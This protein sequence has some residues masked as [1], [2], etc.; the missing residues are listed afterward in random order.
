M[1]MTHIGLERRGEI[2]W[3]NLREGDGHRLEEGSLS[4]LTSTLA[5]LADDPTVRVVVLSGEQGV[6]CSG[7]N[8]D[9][10]RP[11]LDEPAGPRRLSALMQQVAETPLPLIAAI[12]G[13]ALGGGLELA[14]A[15][16]VRLAAEGTRFGFPE[17]TAGMPP[18]GGGASRLA[19]LT[20]PGLALR[21][22]LTGETI[23]ADE[24][25]TRGLV[26]GVYPADKLSREAERLAGVIAARGPIAV[27][28][29]KEAVSRGLEMPLDQ[30]LRFETDLTI[31]LQSTA[32]RAEGVRAFAEKRPPRF[33]GL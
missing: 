30:A 2:A 4:R 1:V 21:L 31:I 13:E 18:L 24:A 10:V 5:A 27:R 7:W 20:G 22:L 19:R 28:Y 6:F 15:C 17:S 33:H 14:L 11:L 32:D 9:A 23:D 8:W 26:S 16:D 25:L 3:L 29:A 12:A